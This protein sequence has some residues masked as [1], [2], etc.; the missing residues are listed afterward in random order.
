MV[1]TRHNIREKRMAQG[2]SPSPRQ[3]EFSYAAVGETQPEEDECLMASFDERER[4]FI[5][6][7]CSPKSHLPANR[8]GLYTDFT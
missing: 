5:R 4:W 3:F 7:G 6:A 1:I 8:I 2:Y